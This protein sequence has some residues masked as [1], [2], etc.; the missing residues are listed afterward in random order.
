MD[1]LSFYS[2][3]YLVIGLGAQRDH[4]LHNRP[5]Q[6]RDNQKVQAITN[7]DEFLVYQSSGYMHLSQE[8][9][10]QF[11][12]GLAGELFDEILNAHLRDPAEEEE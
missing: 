6:D 10:A 12:R 8:R 4:D 1:Q 9:V 5:E 2:S 7:A 3:P 11:R